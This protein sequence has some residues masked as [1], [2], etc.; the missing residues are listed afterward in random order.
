ME[1]SDGRRPVDLD[2]DDSLYHRLTKMGIEVPDD[3]RRMWRTECDVHDDP[4]L[5]TLSSM[6]CM[7]QRICLKDCSFGGIYFNDRS[8]KLWKEQSVKKCRYKRSSSRKK[9]QV[10]F[11]LV[12]GY[13]TLFKIDTGP[14]L[15][16]GSNHGPWSKNELCRLL[17]VFQDNSVMESVSTIYGGLK[18]REELDQKS[19]RGASWVEI[20]RLFL[21]KTFKPSP[22]PEWMEDPFGGCEH[23][24]DPS[25]VSTI[26]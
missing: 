4:T 7:I 15:F 1:R 2:V 16:V 20:L 6:K 14:T 10:F 11:S 18:T 12:F 23:V 9:C 17:H 26:R 8:T 13:P 3:L 19:L 22:P 5:K 25:I 21:D 24:I